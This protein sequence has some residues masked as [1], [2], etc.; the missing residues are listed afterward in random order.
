MGD[1]LIRDVPDSVVEQ[2]KQKAGRHGRSLQQELLK[3]LVESA[4]DPMEKFVEEVKHHQARYKA[5]GR[6]FPD[7]T[8]VIRAGRER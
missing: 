1:V 2:L 8:E 3:V 4:S 6:V 5:A 7:S